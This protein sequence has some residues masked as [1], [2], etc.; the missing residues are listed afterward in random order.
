M[1]ERKLPQRKCV[2][3]MNVKDKKDLVRIVKN[4]DGEISVDPSGKKAGRGAYIC[5][6][7][8]CLE[9]ARKRN[10]LEY[11]FKCKISS[12]VYDE[13]EKELRDVE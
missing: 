9:Q 1:K 12:D 10:R 6:S 4:S 3:C 11:A 8:E 13:L 5:K 2:G 7:S